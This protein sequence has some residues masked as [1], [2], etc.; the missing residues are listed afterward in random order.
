MSFHRRTNYLK[1]KSTIKKKFYRSYID[2]VGMLYMHKV[3][4]L[5]FKIVKIQFLFVYTLI[6]CDLDNQIAIKLT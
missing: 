4:R 3:Q 6:A 2:T 5:F 1:N